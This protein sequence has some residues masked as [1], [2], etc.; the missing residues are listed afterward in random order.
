MDDVDGVEALP[1]GSHVVE[2][3]RAEGG[4]SPDGH[5]QVELVLGNED[6]AVIDRVAI[7]PRSIGRIVSLIDAAGLPRPQGDDVADAGA[8]RLSAAYVARLVG[9]RVTIVVRRATDPES[10]TQETATVVSYRSAG[11]R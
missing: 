3:R 8:G 5:P 11:R 2:I 6:G 10:P 9:R 1:A 7:S 4:D